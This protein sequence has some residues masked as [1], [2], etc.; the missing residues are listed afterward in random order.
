MNDKKKFFFRKWNKKQN[1]FVS[2]NVIAGFP[3]RFWVI[4]LAGTGTTIKATENKLFDYLSR[5][6]LL[7]ESCFS[8]GYPKMLT[9][10]PVDAVDHNG[11]VGGDGFG[12][13]RHVIVGILEKILSSA[14]FPRVFPHQMIL[15]VN[16]A[17]VHLNGWFVSFSLFLE[18]YASV[19]TITSI[20]V[21]M[22]GWRPR[23]PLSVMTGRLLAAH[24]ISA[25]EKT[26]KKNNKNSHGT[27]TAL[28]WLIRR[29]LHRI[30]L[31][32]GTVFGDF[33]E[34]FG[35]DVF[36]GQLLEDLLRS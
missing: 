10:C 17:P 21:T 3:C 28:E 5:Q 35:F 18:D 6:V 20:G 32:R 1:S 29:H 24:T 14:E 22:Q 34:V 19:L 33:F 7:R 25:L 11:R 12:K 16:D 8:S 23:S 27:S 15:H 36:V 9:G 30:Y 26:T 4:F 13:V 31:G 2:G